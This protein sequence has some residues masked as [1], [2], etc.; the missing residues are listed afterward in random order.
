MREGERI[1]A[2]IQTNSGPPKIEM[3]MTGLINTF[4]YEQAA[5]AKISEAFFIVDPVVVSG[6]FRANGQALGEDLL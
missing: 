1:M 5:K 4:D 6:R 3:D 2:A